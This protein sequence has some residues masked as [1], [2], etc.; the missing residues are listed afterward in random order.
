MGTFN[1]TTLAITPRRPKGTIPLDFLTVTE[2]A[3]FNYYNMI[4]V[5]E[6]Y[7]GLPAELTIYMSYIRGLGDQEKPDHK[8][9][10]DLFNLLFRRKGFERDNMFD[11]MIREFERLSN[12]KKQRPVYLSMAIG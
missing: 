2:R 11:W 5:A 3:L 6:L 10:R 4:K 7:Y 12:G 1:Y 8:Y 9:L